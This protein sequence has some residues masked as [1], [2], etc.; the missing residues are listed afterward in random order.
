MPGLDKNVEICVF[1]FCAILLL[2]CLFGVV[3]I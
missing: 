2:C 1:V 3:P